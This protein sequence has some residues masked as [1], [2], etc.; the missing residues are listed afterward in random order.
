MTP[1]Y[2]QALGAQRSALPAPVQRRAQGSGL[3]AG[4]LRP[5]LGPR[6]GGVTDRRSWE[7]RDLHNGRPCVQRPKEKILIKGTLRG[8][9][10]NGTSVQVL[11]CV[12]SSMP[13]SRARPESIPITKFKRAQNSTAGFPWQVPLKRA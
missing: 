9:G 12:S 7:N 5:T 3:R 13:P 1:G 6:G 11:C 2:S 8:E 10:T 4:T